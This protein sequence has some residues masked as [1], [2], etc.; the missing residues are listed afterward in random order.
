LRQPSSVLQ[1]LFY[2]FTL[3][4]RISLENFL[5]GSAVR[6]LPDEH[7]DGKAHSAYAGTASHDLLIKGNAVKH[8]LISLHKDRSEGSVQ[9]LEGASRHRPEHGIQQA[10]L[11][12]SCRVQ[13][14]QSIGE[15][16]EIRAAN[17][18]ILFPSVVQEPFPHLRRQRLFGR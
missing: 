3:K 12:P 6:D 15:A 5:K 18:A 1:G 4:V 13:G 14:G 11:L 17:M 2:V 7:G 8:V 9:N 10:F 16:Q